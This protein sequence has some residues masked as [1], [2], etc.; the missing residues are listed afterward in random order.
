ML[1]SI[2]AQFENCIP[3]NCLSTVTH[4]SFKV[5]DRENDCCYIC[6]EN[7][8]KSLC[9]F[10]VNN[11]TNKPLNFLAIDKCTLTGDKDKKC[12]C[13][14]FDNSLFYFIEMKTASS[15]SRSKRRG[16][17]YMQLKSTIGIFKERINFDNYEILALISFGQSYTIPRTNSTHMG[18]RKELF[19]LYRAK[20]VEGNLIEFF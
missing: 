11:P 8:P 4:N 14:I 5:F 20:L 1:D 15:A 13:A 10:T 18:R 19:D 9:Y 3:N 7:E 2:P 16:D 12:D 17:A 6:T